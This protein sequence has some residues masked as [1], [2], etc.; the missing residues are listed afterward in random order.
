MQIVV[1]LFFKKQVAINILENQFN[2]YFESTPGFSTGDISVK[3]IR[4]KN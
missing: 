2:I 4:E 3:N 1:E